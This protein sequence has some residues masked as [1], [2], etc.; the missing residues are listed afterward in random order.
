ML[1][2]HAVQPP[3]AG[4]APGKVPAYNDNLVLRFNGVYTYTYETI[5][6]K[7]KTDV[8]GLTFKYKITNPITERANPKRFADCL[9]TIPDGNALRAVRFMDLSNCISMTLLRTQLPAEVNAVPNIAKIKG[10]NNSLVDMN[11]SK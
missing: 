7:A 4:Q 3:K 11:I 5:D 10:N 9:E 6:S 1:L 8:K 2:V